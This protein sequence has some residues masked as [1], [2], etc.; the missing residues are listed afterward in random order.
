MPTET[1]MVTEV[2][3]PC[4]TALGQECLWSSASDQAQ[5]FSD[6][7]CLASLTGV[8]QPCTDVCAAILG[9]QPVPSVE[10]SSHELRPHPVGSWVPCCTGVSVCSNCVCLGAR[11]CLTVCQLFPPVWKALALSICWAPSSPSC[12][13]A[14]AAHPGHCV[15][16]GPV[17][18]VVPPRLLICDQGLH[19]AP[20]VFHRCPCCPA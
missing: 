3:L 16:W 7:T 11:L 20:V 12:A 19:S 1:N 4:P 15:S 9:Q 2:P 17:A 14:Q 6:H 8:L 5:L 10:L 13:L 18:P